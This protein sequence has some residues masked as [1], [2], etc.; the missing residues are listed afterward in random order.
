MNIEK[1]HVSVSLTKMMRIDV[2]SRNPK[3]SDRS[4]I[5]NLHYDRL[6][7]P[8]NCY[9]LE[10]S[11]FNVTSKFIEDAIVHW[12]T[13][14]EKYGLR[15]VEVPI[16]EACSISD[17]EPFRAPYRIVL[18][19]QPPPSGNVM[20]GNGT[21]YFTNSS[22]ALQNAPSADKLIYQ[23]ALLKKFN[24]VLD[25]EAASE[26][27][28]DVNVTYTWGK[29]GY[30]YTQFVHRSG[31]IL[32]QITDEGALCL[33]AN[34]LYNTRSASA[35]DVAGK[36]ET[37]NSHHRPTPASG[38]VGL[39]PQ[40]PSPHPSPLVRASSDVLGSRDALNASGMAGFITPEQIK[41]EL[42]E[43]C[44]DAEKLTAFYKELSERGPA[45]TRKSG[46]SSSSALRPVPEHGLENSIPD[47][48]LPASLVT[49][50]TTPA[51]SLG[52]GLNKKISPQ[53]GRRGS[54]APDIAAATDSS[55]R[56][57]TDSG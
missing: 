57:S 13:Q 24:F 12:A 41:D 45:V 29:L 44:H 20:V 10:L 11:W 7:N 28:P 15:L 1:R 26:F 35:K 37:K 42:E 51:K 31:V 25:L 33:L 48:R 19:V 52:M 34:R 22:F 38:I 30:R 36:F 49:R 5:V 55:R 27:P 3:R 39:N 46:S 14:S 40:N 53:S 56:T 32:A 47:L 6:H 21:A 23:K 50:A 16:A 8:D 18:K 54:I 43:F 17:R 9:H 4:E 2:D